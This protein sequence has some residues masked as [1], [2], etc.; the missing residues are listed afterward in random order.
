MKR[1]VILGSGG[2]IGENALNVVRA[3]PDA[4]DIVGLAVHSNAGRLLEQAREFGVKQLA[5]HDAKAAED[6]ARSADPDMS[7]HAGADGICQLASMDGVDMVVCAV[8]G[9]AG[10][11]PVMGA[12]KKGTDIALATKEVMVAAGE[13]VNALAA[14]NQAA[15][16]PV[17]SEHNAIFQCLEGHPPEHVQ[18]LILTASGGPFLNRPEVDFDQV[19][20]EEALAHPRWDMG[21]KITVDSATMMNKGLEIIE[22]R[23]LFNTPLSQIDVVIHPESIIHSM[24]EFVDGSILAQLSPTDMRFAI[25]HALSWPDRLPASAD[26]LDLLKLGALHFAEPDPGRFPM[27]RL[28]REAAEACGTL[29]AVLNAANEAAVQAFLDGRISFS[30]IWKQVETKMRGHRVINNPSLEDILEADR[31]ARES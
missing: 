12:L 24:V 16:V 15:I 26:R 5:V 8:V 14:E 30:G 31:W 21:P 2:S 17:D 19:S 28:A 7:V 10:L 3:H 22:A 25:Q 4:F 6:C 23:W 18:R 1:I 9:T 13:L 20:V 27:L 11:A 29:P